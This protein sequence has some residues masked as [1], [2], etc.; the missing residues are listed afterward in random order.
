MTGPITTAM[1]K[2]EVT[3]PAC[4]LGK[5]SSRIAFDSGTTGAPIRLLLG[6]A[7]IYVGAAPCEALAEELRAAGADVAAT[8]YPGAQHGYDY[9]GGDY[10]VPSG[11]NFS[12]C[13]FEE[14]ADGRWIERGSNT[15]FT[16]GTP[17]A[18]IA[19]QACMRTGVSG[20]PDG[21]ARTASLQ[22]LLEYVRQYLLR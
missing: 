9:F 11:Q 14:L 10:Y 20:G 5:L 6:A 1:P 21:A 15:P 12:Q 13:R 22:A 16:P 17:S 4:R 3:R 19:A 2:T 7:D 8:I 18:R